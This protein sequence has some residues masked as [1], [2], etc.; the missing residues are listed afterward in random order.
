MSALTEFGNFA[1]AVHAW[2]R[3]AVFGGI[4]GPHCERR[5][6]GGIIGNIYDMR[7]KPLVRG[8]MQLI[9]GYVPVSFHTEHDGA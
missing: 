4:A 9:E 5:E 2:S 8:K 6:H 1:V 7:I 3:H